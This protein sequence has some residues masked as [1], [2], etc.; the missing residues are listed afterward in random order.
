MVGLS[1]SMIADLMLVSLTAIIPPVL[2][3]PTLS[4]A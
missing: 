3:N 1:T 2:S 4:K